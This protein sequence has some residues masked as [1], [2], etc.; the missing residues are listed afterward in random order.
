MKIAK[1]QAVLADTLALCHSSYMADTPL[2][3]AGASIHLMARSYESDGRGFFAAGDLVNALASYWYASGWLHFGITYGLLSCRDPDIPCI[4]N[5]P[6]DQMPDNLR[7]KLG[8]KTG[9]Y[10]RLLDT[11]RS[12]VQPAPDASAPGHAFAL[13]V[14]CISGTYAGYGNLFRKNGM[15]E[16]A[17]ACF[18]YGHGWIDAAV[19]AGLFAIQSN[20]DIFTV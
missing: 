19:M 1:C 5:G 15:D 14:L 17:L 11:A 16:R 9:R 12:S 10:A 6:D 8:E 20:R 13:Q 7:E 4:F 18:S 3:K 2:G